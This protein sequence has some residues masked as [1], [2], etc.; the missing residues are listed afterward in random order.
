ME[1][2][3]LTELLFGFGIGLSLAFLATGFRYVLK[4]FSTVGDS[5]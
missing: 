1:I 5:G 4:S 2:N 3:V